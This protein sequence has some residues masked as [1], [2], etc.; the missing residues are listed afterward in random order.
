LANW[1]EVMLAVPQMPY[2]IRRA[3]VDE[4][5]LIADLRLF[6]L[7]SLELKRYPLEAADAVRAWLPDVDDKLIQSGHYFVAEHEGDLIGGAGWSVL[8]LQFRTDRLIQ[9][10]GRAAF[11]SLDP[12]SV[13][14]R[15]FFL[16]P[17]CGR[18]GV[19]ASLLRQIEPD[20]AAEGYSAAEVVVPEDAQLSY[21]SL[22]FKAVRSFSLALDGGDAVPLLQM[23]RP[24]APALRLAAAA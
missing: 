6:S 14:L 15:G 24:F 19:S 12:G 4:T 2:A 16:D 22:G 20:A 3:A 5:R 8:P 18:R 23:R 7:L 17:D 1:I 9:E 21:R 13:L 10:G 11:L